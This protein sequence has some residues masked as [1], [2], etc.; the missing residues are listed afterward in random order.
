MVGT[1]LRRRVR[2]FDD[3]GLSAADSFLGR[4]IGESQKIV[5]L[6]GGNGSLVEGKAA[7]LV[8]QSGI[9]VRIGR[10]WIVGRFPSS[11]LDMKAP[12]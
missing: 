10:L 2:V 5:R 1:V 12:I 11:G 3:R 9:Q 8:Y 6:E 7:F 4:Q